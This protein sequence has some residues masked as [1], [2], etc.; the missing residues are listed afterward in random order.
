MSPKQGGQFG[1]EIP[2]D[3]SQVAADAGAQ[4]LRVV[5]RAQ[6]GSLTSGTVTG[7]AAGRATVRL[8][9]P[10]RPGPLQILVGP[11]SATDAQLLNLQTISVNVPGRTCGE[12]GTVTIDPIV[13]AP[14]H[15]WW[16]LDWCRTFVI[17]GALFP[18]PH[19]YSRIASASRTASAGFPALLA[20]TAW[21]IM[22]RA[23][24]SASSPTAGRHARRSHR[25]SATRRG[26]RRIALVTAGVLAGL[27]LAFLPLP[28]AVAEAQVTTTTINVDNLAVGTPVAQYPATNPEITFPAETP[29]F[30]MAPPGSPPG[31]GVLAAE[32]CPGPPV[33]EA[34]GPPGVNAL[35]MSLCGADEFPYHGVFA[36]LTDTADSVS[37]IVGDPEGFG[38]QFELDAYD[39]DGNLIGEATATATSTGV[40]TPITYSQPGVF[41]IAYVALYLASGA[42]DHDEIG[43]YG[44]SV[45]WGG[46]AP[47]ITIDSVLATHPLAPGAQM[48]LTLTIGRHNGSDGDVD[49]TVAGLP[50]RIGVTLSPAVLTGT[51]ETSQVTITVASAAVGSY[52]GTLTATPE[53]PESGSNPVSG[54]VYVDVVFPFSVSSPTISTTTPT[55][56]VFPCSTASAVIQTSVLG[57]YTGTP[58]NLAVSTSGDTSNINDIFLPDPVLNNPGDFTAGVNDQTLRVSRFTEPSSTSSFQVSVTP[59]SGAFTG[60]PVTI[61][62]EQ[63]QPTIDSLSTD[64]V[65]T[66]QGPR[67]GTDLAIDG[68]GFCQDV[69]VQFGNKFATAT[70]FS[71][72]PDPANPGLQQVLVRTPPLATNGPVTVENIDSHNQPSSQVTSA[73]SLDVDSYRN[74]DGY[75]FSNY[76]PYIDYAQ[77]TE[78]FGSSQTYITIDLCWPLGCDVTVPNPFAA[79]VK[80]IA[81]D[82]IGGANGGACYGFALSTQRLLLGQ[83]SYGDYPPYDPN[84]DAFGLSGPTGPSGPLT[85]FINATAVSQ[86]NATLQS[87][88]N[89]QVN[90]HV[91]VGGAASAVEV[92]N[93]IKNILAQGRFPIISLQ[94]SRGGHAVDAYALQ[95]APPNYFIDVYDSNEPFLPAENANA[96]LH[97]SQFNNS[98]IS[99]NPQGAWSLPSTQISGNMTGLVVLDPAQQPQDPVMVDSPQAWLSSTGNGSGAPPSNITQISDAS[100]RTLLNGSG[101]INTNL[102]T[103]LDGTPWEPMV[104]D[105]TAAS[106]VPQMFLFSA[107]DSA[108]DATVR[109]TGHGTDTHTFFMGLG[110]M[111]EISTTASPR[112]IDHLLL[113]PSGGVG[114]TTSAASQPVTLTV[115]A[116]QGS[117][118]R[119]AQLAAAVGHGG[120]DSLSFRPGRAGLSIDNHGA[121]P[122]TFT[123]TLSAE[124]LTAAPAE[125]QSGPISVG[126]HSTATISAIRWNALTSS[127]LKVTTSGHARTIGSTYRPKSL[128]AIASLSAGKASKLATSLSV[129]FRLHG[130]PA[131]SE[132]LVTWVVQKSGHVVATRAEQVSPHAS[133]ARYHFRGQRHGQFTVTATVTVITT[134]GAASSSTQTSRRLR[135]RV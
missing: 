53:S 31:K 6:D 116:S 47:S 103:R 119:T 131:D 33:V 16:W 26:L 97:Q 93:Q 89:N 58:I 69:A 63:A 46:G 14:Y 18:A 35:R 56:S 108:L 19:A 80:R 96:G 82:T 88:T 114:M 25:D 86:F 85:D 66:P 90:Q 60:T 37:A 117:D 20:A 50:P 57:G 73:E 121:K 2:I 67:A 78:A 133:T 122:T 98:R 113:E 106:A 65:E 40:T 134:Q 112:T 45:E 5:A 87:E 100:G 101:G 28:S 9:F 83:A 29:G 94:S 4:E 21:S 12:A 41:T 111:G 38:G 123:L 75:Q 129:R 127:T 36:E 64:F 130:L 59:S 81:N 61:T 132:V 135:F 95:G 43:M 39:A 126:P 32:A 34:V 125:F 24:V 42:T 74:V 76:K 77:L 13:V 54:P 104:D 107:G 7:E 102:T 92:Y 109:E 62:F 118:V 72:G 3:L 128:A 115:T 48:Q 84:S 30:T 49:L 22:I 79:N 17:R 1:L 70:A 52:Q 124:G 15:W 11:G 120:G 51:G 10:H 71:V 44:F 105:T 68:T 27:P 23:R 99:V 8:A 110:L 55:V 91:A